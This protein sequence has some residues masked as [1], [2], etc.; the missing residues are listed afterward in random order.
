[1]YLIKFIMDIL[2]KNRFEKTLRKN[3]LLVALEQLF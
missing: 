1:M 3:I 2:F